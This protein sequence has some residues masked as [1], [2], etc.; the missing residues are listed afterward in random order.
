MSN[1][2]GVFPCTFLI[3]KSRSSAES[4]TAIFNG[5]LGR[6]TIADAIQSSYF[7]DYFDNTFS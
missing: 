6:H 5:F 2:A 3:D 7:R 4:A 1:F